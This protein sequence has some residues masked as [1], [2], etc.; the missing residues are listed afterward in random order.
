[1]GTPN[2]NNPELMIALFLKVMYRSH[3]IQKHQVKQK[4]TELSQEELDEIRFLT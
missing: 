1:M 3:L 2:F 4:E